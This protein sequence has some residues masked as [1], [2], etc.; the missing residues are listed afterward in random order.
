MFSTVDGEG[1]A[2]DKTLGDRG[3]ASD[4][5]LGDRDGEP[6]GRSTRSDTSTSF[7]FVEVP[8]VVFRAVFFALTIVV[9]GFRGGGTRM[10]EDE[11]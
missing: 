5:T 8:P 9:A 11:G 7:T 10:R 3:G 4:K 6:R 1:G 2:C